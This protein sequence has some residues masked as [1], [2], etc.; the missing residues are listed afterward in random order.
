M[1]SVG[2]SNPLHIYGGTTPTHS[3]PNTRKRWVISTMLK[4]LY[5]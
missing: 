3:K 2:K 1:T 4:P 5:P